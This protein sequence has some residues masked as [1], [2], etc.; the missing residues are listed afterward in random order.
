MIHVGLV[1]LSGIVGIA[2]QV[3]LAELVGFVEEIIMNQ[4][5]NIQRFIP[6]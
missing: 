1:V 5:M 2:G 3:V 4:A 6:P